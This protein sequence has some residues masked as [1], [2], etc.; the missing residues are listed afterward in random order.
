MGGASG[1][2]SG[3]RTGPGGS[4]VSGTPLPPAS[5]SVAQ[6]QVTLL[7]PRAGV[8]P[9]GGPVEVS[10]APLPAHCQ[11]PFAAS[12]TWLQLASS[13]ITPTAFRFSAAPNTSPLVRTATVVVGDQ[14]FTVEQ[15]GLVRT[16]LAASP[17]RVVVGLSPKQPPRKREL[18]IW[19]DNDAAGLTVSASAPWIRLSPVRSRKPGRKL[20]EVNVDEEMLTGGRRHEG[21]IIV[22]AD[23]APPLEIPVVVEGLGRL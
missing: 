23:G 9:N 13:G 21:A 5:A 18:A 15:A 14:V 7:N 4:G 10:I 12:S 1:A 3:G 17:A 2:V 11:P 16:R 20:F 6:C 19:A 22:S 8:G